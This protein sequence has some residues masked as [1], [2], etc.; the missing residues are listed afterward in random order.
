MAAEDDTGIVMGE[1]RTDAADDIVDRA[2]RVL[3]PGTTGC[4]SRGQN[5]TRSPENTETTAVDLRL[6]AR[7]V[8][9]TEEERRECDEEKNTDGLGVL[10]A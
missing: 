3:S 2:W 10:T 5:D 6:L 4:A 8:H 1:V 7:G 9:G